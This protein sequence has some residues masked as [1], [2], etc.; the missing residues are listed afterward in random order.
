MDIDKL[1]VRELKNGYRYDRCIN[2]YVCNLC[3]K[4][5]EEGEIFPIDDKLFEASKAV[6]IHLEREHGGSFKCLI[7]S[8]SKYN[9][10]TD[11]Q[12]ELL[13]FMYSNDSDKEI[14]KKLGISP[15]TV[16]H[17]RFMFREKAKQAKM[18]LAIYEQVNER[19]LSD[20]DVIVG[21]HDSATMLDDRYITTEKEKAD[22]L[23]NA[24]LSLDPLKLKVFPAK[25]KKK[26]IVLARIAEQFDSVKHY[27]EK[28][29][30]EILKGNFDDH[31][32]IRRY[33]IEYGFMDRTSDCNEYWRK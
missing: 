9:T 33:L 18:Y 15:S 20:D 4:T 14:A 23:R 24:F 27:S 5:Y 22:I 12:K 1:T 13:I 28:E 29:V 2:A 31:V 17:Q 11:N 32:T 16:R 26:V 10:L 8:G 25:E 6:K 19:P 30:N 3:M 7:G 21:V